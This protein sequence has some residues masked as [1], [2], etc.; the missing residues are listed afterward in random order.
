MTNPVTDAV[1]ARAQGERAE[2]MRR[3]EAE[4]AKLPS[5]RELRAFFASP[6]G[7][8]A[9]RELVDAFLLADP[10]GTEALHLGIWLGAQKVVKWLLRTGGED[11][12]ALIQK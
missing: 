6:A 3:I 2:Q 4:L 9:A 10:P 7:H 11:I 8:E 5:A 12:P 1:R